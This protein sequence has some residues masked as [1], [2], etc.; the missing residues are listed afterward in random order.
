M[1]KSSG[2]K[3]LESHNEYMLTIP[4]WEKNP[5]MDRFMLGEPQKFHTNAMEFSSDKHFK[6]QFGYKSLIYMKIGNSFKH[7]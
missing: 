4:W 5:R 1:P 2:K 6:Q 3:S 7:I